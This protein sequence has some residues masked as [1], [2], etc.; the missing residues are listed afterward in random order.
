MVASLD[1]KL[2]KAMRII[3]GLRREIYDAKRLEDLEEIIKNLREE[4]AV[5]KAHEPQDLSDIV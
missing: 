3:E 5:L 4:V 1:E 2:E